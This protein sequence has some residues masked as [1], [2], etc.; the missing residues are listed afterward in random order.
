M[1]H[2]YFLDPEA[3]L[4][5]PLGEFDLLLVPA[6]VAAGLI[7]RGMLQ[8]MAGPPGRAHDPEGAYTVPYTYRVAA[9]TYPDGW[10]AT[11]APSWTDLWR[12][13]VQAVWPASARLAIGAA[14]LRRGHSP[15]DTHP[16]HLAQAEQDLTQLRPQ[17][18]TDAMLHLSASTDS[19]PSSG[20]DFGA[21]VRR[22]GGVRPTLAFSLATLDQTGNPSTARLPVEGVPLLEYDWAI[23]ID[24]RGAAAARDFLRRMGRAVERAPVARTVALIPLMPLPD[25]A[26]AQHAQIWSALMAQRS[27]AVA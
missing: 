8:A 2:V 3:L 5:R 15:N 14:L 16:G 6:Y 23:P 17:I 12:A 18:V 19:P 22:A 20:S 13:E 11:A 4:S 24:A 9:L 25:I 27:T 1:P 21:Q 26:R 10:P 7:R